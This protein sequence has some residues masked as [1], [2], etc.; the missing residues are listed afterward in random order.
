MPWLTFTPN[1]DGY[2]CFLWT[3]SIFLKVFSSGILEASGFCL[4]PFIIRNFPKPKFFNLQ[5]KHDVFLC[6]NQSKS[7]P[8]LGL[9]VWDAEIYH[10]IRRCQWLANVSG[11]ASLIALRASAHTFLS[12]STFLIFM[13]SKTNVNLKTASFIISFCPV[14]N[15]QKCSLSSPP[16]LLLAPQASFRYS[17]L[18][19]PSKAAYMPANRSFKWQPHSTCTAHPA[20]AQTTI[21]RL[22][23]GVWKP[24]LHAAVGIILL[25]VLEVAVKQTRWCNER[26]THKKMAPSIN[27]SLI[28][29][30]NY[31]AAHAS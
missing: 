15:T 1:A 22:S 30:S 8:T 13:T 29:L 5:P 4:E 12:H 11:V 14:Q 18:E 6:F 2:K 16:A 21:G 23:P 31:Y 9:D 28:L 26:S 27:W 20:A 7:P 25:G 24:Y 3:L 17:H 19:N 10:A